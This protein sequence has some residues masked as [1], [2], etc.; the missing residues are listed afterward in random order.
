MAALC[1]WGASRRKSR[2]KTVRIAGIPLEPHY[3]SVTGNGGRDGWKSVGIGQSAARSDRTTD[4]DQS[5]SDI[6]AAYEVFRFIGS[7]STWS[8][9]GFVMQKDFGLLFFAFQK[10]QDLLD[11]PYREGVSPDD[12]IS[13]PT[14]WQTLPLDVTLSE[15]GNPV[16]GFEFAHRQLHT[17][18]ELEAYR[19][20]FGG[21]PLNEEATLSIH[22]AGDVSGFDICHFCGS[23]VQRLSRKGVGPSGP[24][25]MAYTPSSKNERAHD[26][27]VCSAPKDAAALQKAV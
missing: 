8:D 18:P 12:A 5:A 16:H 14:R 21:E 23:L 15:C 22:Y 6:F 25:H 19:A 13:R 24:K 17:G 27:V 1:S 4:S 26:D 20:S 10:R 11:K 9:R 2:V 7:T 3:H